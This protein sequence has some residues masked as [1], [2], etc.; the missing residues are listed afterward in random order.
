MTT[1][2]PMIFDLIGLDENRPLAVQLAQGGSFRRGSVIC[3]E[4]IAL[5]EQAIAE[6]AI[7][8]PSRGNPC[9]PRG[10][11]AVSSRPG[12]T[13][14]IGCEPVQYPAPFVPWWKALPIVGTHLPSPWRN[15]LRGI[16]ETV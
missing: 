13:R 5:M 15:K 10:R 6:H 12:G 11:L 4:E 8:L 7:P 9:R 16:A 1:P 2:G 14:V 3:G